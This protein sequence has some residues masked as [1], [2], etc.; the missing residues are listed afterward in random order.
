LEP[1]RR[2]INEI[3]VHAGSLY[4][5]ETKKEVFKVPQVATGIVVVVFDAGL[6]WGAMAYMALPD[7]KIT[8]MPGEAR[9]KF[10]DVALPSFIEELR[11]KGVDP[12]NC[13]VLLIGGSQLFNF[14]G[15]SGNILNIGTRNAI[16]ARA[17]LTKEGFMIERADTGGNKP[18]NIIFDSATGLVEV[19]LP[20]S[21]A[22]TL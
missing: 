12:Q 10:V 8:P 9:L 5:S 15:R 3:I 2:V 21:T 17:I 19:L 6:S 20:G 14:G 16:T 7:S 1:I 4:F 22:K 11:K 13:R 18:R